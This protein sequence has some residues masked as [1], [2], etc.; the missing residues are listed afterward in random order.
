MWSPRAEFAIRE[1]LLAFHLGPLLDTII[2]IITV[3][4]RNPTVKNT[5]KHWKNTKS[6]RSWDDENTSLFHFLFVLDFLCLPSW[7][8][9]FKTEKKKCLKFPV[10]VNYHFPS[11]GN[12]FLAPGFSWNIEIGVKII[13]FLAFLQFINV[14]NNL[15]PPSLEKELKMS[16]LS[17]WTWTSYSWKTNMQYV[18]SRRRRHEICVEAETESESAWRISTG[19]LIGRWITEGCSSVSFDV[20]T[21]T[22]KTP[23]ENPSASNSRIV[24]LL[25]FACHRCTTIPQLFY[26]PLSNQKA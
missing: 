17:K 15:T 19:Y 21:F 18:M 3:I 12:G 4:F 14:L 20:L 8:C 25:N 10:V 26:R 5:R 7:S 11:C 2:S 24:S 23:L 22:L 16:V 13:H 1:L 6:T 9:G